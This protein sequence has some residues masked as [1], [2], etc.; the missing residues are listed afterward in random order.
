MAKFAEIEDVV[1]L[2]WQWCQLQLCDEV[3][4]AEIKADVLL[5][6]QCCQLQ[7]CDECLALS[8]SGNSLLA[9]ELKLSAVFSV[10]FLWFTSLI[11]HYLIFPILFEDCNQL[12]QWRENIEL[13]LSTNTLYY[14]YLSFV[15]SFIYLFAIFVVKEDEVWIFESLLLIINA[16]II[17]PKS[18]II[19]III[20]KFLMFYGLKPYFLFYMFLAFF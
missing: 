17:I 5:F 9:G 6:W 10:I 2:F 8:E 15:S 1:V 13:H 16:I 14:E 12:S 7:L 18:F 4:R 19:I 20:P 3:E 11:I